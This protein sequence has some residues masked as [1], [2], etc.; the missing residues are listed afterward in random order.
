MRVG[1]LKN[2]K[3]AG[4]DEVIEEMIK[5]GELDLEAM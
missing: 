3:V 2:E 5:G 1:R 4:K